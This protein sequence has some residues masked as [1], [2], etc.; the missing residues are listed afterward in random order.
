MADR[1]MAITIKRAKDD[2]PRRRNGAVICAIF[3]RAVLNMTRSPWEVSLVRSPCSTAKLRLQGRIGQP[4]L[5][6]KW[7]D[8][9]PVGI[10][11]NADLWEIG[12]INSRNTADQHA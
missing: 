12:Q 11:V 6:T 2:A 4:K 3:A 7:G 1:P 5:S 10:T 8:G 9:H